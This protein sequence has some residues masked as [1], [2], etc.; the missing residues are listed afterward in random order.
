MT[1]DFI[2]FYSSSSSSL[3]A[4]GANAL[5]GAGDPGVMGVDAV[6]PASKRNFL[7]EGALRRT[8]LAAIVL[9]SF[10]KPLRRSSIVMAEKRPKRQHV[11]E[12]K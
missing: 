10:S 4:G 7:R 5:A 1:C 6:V 9:S 8:A 11:V 3:A 12:I 2:M